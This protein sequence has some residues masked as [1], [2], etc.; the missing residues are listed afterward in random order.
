M[1]VGTAQ[2]DEA[3]G[4]PR[5]ACARVTPMSSSEVQHQG[6]CGNGAHVWP[7]TCEQVGDVVTSG[8]KL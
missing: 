5:D 3:C 8:W 7:I 1:A 2:W 4:S 6:A